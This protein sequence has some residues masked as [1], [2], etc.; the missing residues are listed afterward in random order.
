MSFLICKLW[1]LGEV[2]FHVPFLLSS[3]ESMISRE[4]GQVWQ[5]P[6]CSPFFSVSWA[7]L[8]PHEQVVSSICASSCTAL[9]QWPEDARCGCGEESQ[10]GAPGPWATRAWL[11]SSL[12]LHRC[13]VCWCDMTSCSPTSSITYPCAL[14]SVPEWAIIMLLTF[15]AVSCLWFPETNSR[16]LF[17]QPQGLCSMFS[18][19]SVKPDTTHRHRDTCALYHG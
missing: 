15:L 16:K 5:S 19:F 1:D 8:P 14:H 4:T 18:S 9:F 11:V 13:L 7:C 2:I 10:P 6:E 3:S 17:S 12:S